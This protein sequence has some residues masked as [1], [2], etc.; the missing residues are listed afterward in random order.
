VG[1]LAI[2]KPPPPDLLVY[3][4]GASRGNPG[5]AAIGVSVQTPEGKELDAVGELIGRGTHNQAEYTAALRGLELASTRTRGI[6][7]LRSDSELMV[8]QLTGANQ[9]REPRLV[10]LQR[11][12]RAA[13]GPFVR[14]SY[15]WVPREEAGCARADALAN[16]ALN[17]AGHPKKERRGPKRP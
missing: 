15:V 12:L 4:D 6:V 11:R 14:V 5:P 2:D 3:V 17:A 13:Q 16:A 8:K 10:E 1:P 9:T 7:E